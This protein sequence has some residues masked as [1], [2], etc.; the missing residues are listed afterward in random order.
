MRNRRVQS[1]G[2][3]NEVLLDENLVQCTSLQLRGISESDSFHPPAAHL[4]PFYLREHSKRIIRGA[5]WNDSQFLAKL[6]IMDYSLLVA[7][8]NERNELVVGI[9]G[10][11]APDSPSPFALTSLPLK[12]T[13]AHTRGTSG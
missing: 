5:I 7:V 8:E 2:R 3:P 11:S 1:T 10:K 12:I 13:S 4:L 9:V 6:N